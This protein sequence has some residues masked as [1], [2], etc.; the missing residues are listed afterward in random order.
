MFVSNSIEDFRLNQ[1]PNLQ[2]VLP[3]RCHFMR[4][5]VNSIKFKV[6]HRLL[7]CML[8]VFIF[9]PEVINLERTTQQGVIT[10]A[11]TS[12][13]VKTPKSFLEKVGG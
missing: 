2:L 4:Y 9:F 10:R 12:N 1:F 7:H 13:S 3:M 5:S 6:P 11:N 8:E